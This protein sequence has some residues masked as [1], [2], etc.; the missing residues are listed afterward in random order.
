MEVASPPAGLLTLIINS[1]PSVAAVNLSSLRI[2]AVSNLSASCHRHAF[3]MLSTFE[4]NLITV[5]L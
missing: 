3:A 5:C 1:V 4:M 2:A